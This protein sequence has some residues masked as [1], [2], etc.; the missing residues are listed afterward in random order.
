MAGTLPRILHSLHDGLWIEIE[1]LARVR[2]G[3]RE[4]LK[5]VLSVLLAVFIA[6]A[7]HLPDIVW[8]ALSGFL[9]MR[10]SMAEAVPRA[11]QRMAGTI[12]GGLL[13]LLLARW[14]AQD[15]GL[16]MI[17]LFLLI[18]VAV[19][20]GSVTGARY[21]WALFGVTAALVL[22]AALGS[23]EGAPAFAA[24]RAAEVAIGSGAALAIAALFE[25][26]GAPPGTAAPAGA[27]V[28]T[29]VLTL[30]N[31]TEEAWLA[32]NW[33]VIIHATQA[34]LAVSLLPLVWRAFEITNYLQ[35]AITAFI[36]M[37]VPLQAIESGGRFAVYERMAHRLTGCLIG[38]VVALVALHVVADD[39]LLWTL[40]LAAGV[41]AGYHIQCGRGGLSYL[42]TQFAFAFLVS[43]VQGSGPSVSIEPPLT[44]LLGVMIGVGM[45]SLV[46][47]AWPSTPGDDRHRA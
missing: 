39:G 33:P 40:C 29:A 32:R 20:Q 10:S 9:V 34:A 26:F 42:G 11:L 43:F 13:G 19:Y 41:W 27:A 30:R 22:V 17:A 6:M 31:L 25:A 44:R 38:G 8:A 36:V 28:P 37:I 21:A 18:W 23:P 46:I 3:W 15:V 35:T 4:P 12:A 7:M 1:D 16:L 24:V 5:A 45:A 2:E 47:L 14:T